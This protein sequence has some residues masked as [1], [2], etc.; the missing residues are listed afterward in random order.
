MDIATNPIAPFCYLFIY[1]FFNNFSKISFSYLPCG[2][3][4]IQ[5][6]VFNHPSIIW[7]TH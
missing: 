5:N 7:P 6:F 3:I 2:F 1:S 4:G